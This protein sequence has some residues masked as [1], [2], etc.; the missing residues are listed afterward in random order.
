MSRE[1]KLKKLIEVNK[2]VFRLADPSNPVTLSTRHLSPKENDRPTFEHKRV[3]IEDRPIT[4]EEVEELKHMDPSEKLKEILLQ[5]KM[6]DDSPELPKKVRKILK[7]KLF[8][9]DD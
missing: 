1:E 7:Q 2:P 4:A 9:G 6:L 3:L 5:R 8:L